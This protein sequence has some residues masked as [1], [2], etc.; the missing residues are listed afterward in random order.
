VVK[1]ILTQDN[2]NG[3][4]GKRIVVILEY[5]IEIKPTKLI[6]GHG[7]AKLMAES[8]FHALDINFLAAVDG[9]EEQVT[10][11]IKEV[12]LNSPWYA[13]LIFILQN[14]QAPPSLTKTKAKFIKLKALKF[15]ILERNLYWKDPGGVFLN[16]LLKDEAH[17]VLQDFHAGDCGGNL[18]WK[19]TTNK[20]MRVGFYWPTL[21]ADIHQKVTSCHR[22]QIFEGKRKLLPLPMKHISVE[23]PFQ[24]WGLEFIGEIHPSSLGQHKWILTATDYFTKWIEVVPCTQAPDYVIIKFLET[25]ILSHLGCPIKIVA[26]NAAAFRSKRLI[27]FCS[28]YL[29]TLG[30]STTYYP[31]GNGLVESSNKSLVIILRKEL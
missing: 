9:P 22:C 3:R 18:S 28:Q 26:N 4:R 1:D 8:N 15:C 12:F 7:L 23:S 29:F 21:F 27:D 17:K 19:T 24:Q 16:C 6:K 11:N 30:H 10:P 31:Q 14:L 5:D 2:P 13:N 20:I 25:N